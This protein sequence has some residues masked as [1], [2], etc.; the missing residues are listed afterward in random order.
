MCVF[1]SIYMLHQNF[2]TTEAIQIK[3]RTNILQKKTLEI[4]TVGAR[5]LYK[6]VSICIQLIEDS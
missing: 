1:V 2:E 4:N 6:W 3:L 5:Q